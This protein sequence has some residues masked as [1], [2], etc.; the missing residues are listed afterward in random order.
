MKV[1]NAR[2]GLTECA[3]KSPQADGPPAAPEAES[4][5]KSIGNERIAEEAPAFQEAC[6]V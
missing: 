5:R 1:N 3:P 4:K 2:P 6:A